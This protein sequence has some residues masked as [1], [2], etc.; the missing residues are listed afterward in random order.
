MEFGTDGSLTY[1]IHLADRT[2]ILKLSYEVD[3]D[4]IWTDQ[5]SAPRKESTRFSIDA[6][7]VLELD[8]AG[9]RSWYE[10]V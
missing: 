7:G 9:E 5:P 1:S 3:G 4:T 2:Q 6:R 8:K 10:R